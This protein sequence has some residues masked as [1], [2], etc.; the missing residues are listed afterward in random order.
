[1]EIANRELSG[2]EVLLLLITERCCQA[3]AKQMKLPAGEN[4]NMN[5]H[6]AS[7]FFV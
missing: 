5:V 1:M 4:E 3:D 6:R 7:D 2:L